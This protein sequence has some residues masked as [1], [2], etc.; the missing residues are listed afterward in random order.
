[1]SLSII[2]MEKNDGVSEFLEACSDDTSAYF[3]LIYGQ[4]IVKDLT[5]LIEYFEE[6]MVGI[7]YYDYI[8]ESGPK[9]FNSFS[10]FSIDFDRN[11]VVSKIALDKVKDKSPK[12]FHSLIKNIIEMGFI[13]I[14][15]PDIL[16]KS[17]E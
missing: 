4:N 9:H 6:P 3:C 12:T 10:Q 13:A 17:D 14:N 15:I 5:Y 1:M 16:T 8:D 11:I 2:K 7:L